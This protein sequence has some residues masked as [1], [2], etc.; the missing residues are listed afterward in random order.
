LVAI[1]HSVDTAILA[2]LPVYQDNRAVRWVFYYLSGVV[3]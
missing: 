1:W 2:G 3:K